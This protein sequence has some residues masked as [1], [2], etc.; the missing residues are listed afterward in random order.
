MEME[1]TKQLF[2]GMDRKDQLYFANVWGIAVFGLF[3]LF[4]FTVAG[5]DTAL[6]VMVILTEIFGVVTLA[7]GIAGIIYFTGERRWF[8]I[9]VVSFLS[10]W[11]IFAIGYEIGLGEPMS[12]YWLLFITYYIFLIASVVF[13]RLSYS[14]IDNVLKVVPAVFLFINALLTLYMVFLNMWWGLTA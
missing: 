13:I 6:R 7:A 3:L 11:A 1:R 12:N 9:A 8:S 5:T 4:T 14:R 2:T 10:V